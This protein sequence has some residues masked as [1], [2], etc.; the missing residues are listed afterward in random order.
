MWELL[1]IPLIAYIVCTSVFWTLGVILS[2]RRGE[3]IS[4]GEHEITELL[5][6]LVDHVDSATAEDHATTVFCPGCL[7]EIQRSREWLDENDPTWKERRTFS[8]DWVLDHG[9]ETE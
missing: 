2:W 4:E 8:L 3:I 5:G 1:A 9:A 6:D 7:Y